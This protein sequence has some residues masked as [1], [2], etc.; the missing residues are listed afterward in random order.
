MDVRE[1]APDAPRLAAAALLA[2]RP[3]WADAETV[4]PA[5]REPHHATIAVTDPN[6]E[7]VER[8]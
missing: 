4:V 5:P 8:A 3:M 2:L 6:R 7:R 1:L